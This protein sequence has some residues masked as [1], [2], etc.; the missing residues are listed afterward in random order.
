MI[1]VS[2]SFRS[3]GFRM[4]MVTMWQFNAT[5]VFL[6]HGTYCTHPAS[7]KDSSRVA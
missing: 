7:P 4:S 3:L 1:K 6:G 5:L 2:V